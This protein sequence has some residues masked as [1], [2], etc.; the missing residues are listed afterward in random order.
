MSDEDEQS[1]DDILQAIAECKVN[2]AI[3]EGPENLSTH[4]I[5]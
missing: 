3:A 4:F 1:I 2:I 5:L